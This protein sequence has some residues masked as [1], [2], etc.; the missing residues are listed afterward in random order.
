MRRRTFAYYLFD[1]HGDGKVALCCKAEPGV[2]QALVEADPARCFVPAYLGAK[3][4][5]AVRLDV[6]RVGW[7]L[8][9][10]LARK[11][12]QRTAPKGLASRAG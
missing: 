10:E 11:A 1:H 4:W 3:G 5:V 6:M 7:P 12:Y 8:I 2:Q 9:A